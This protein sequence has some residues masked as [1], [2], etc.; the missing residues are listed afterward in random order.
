M[1]STGKIISQ[2]VETMLADA[3]SEDREA[4]SSS[5]VRQI[6]SKKLTD[7]AD[8]LGVSHP[9]MPRKIKS[10]TWSSDDLDRLAI[11]FHVYPDE[12]VPGPNDD[13]GIEGVSLRSGTSGTGG[14]DHKKPGLGD[15]KTE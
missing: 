15:K 6:Y 7:L 12:F 1:R 4:L 5:T 11:F 10:G 2:T 14:P 9:Y 8:F 3:V 13:W